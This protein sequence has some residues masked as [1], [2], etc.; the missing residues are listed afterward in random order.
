MGRESR[1]ASCR[2][3]GS[4]S[5]KSRQQCRGL[6]IQIPLPPSGIPAAPSIQQQQLV[7]WSWCDAA[8]WVHCSSQQR[9][10]SE[11]RVKRGGERRKRG[12]HEC[13]WIQPAEEGC[14]HALKGRC[15]DA[16]EGER[17][18]QDASYLGRACAKVKPCDR[19]LPLP[20]RGKRLRD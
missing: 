5:E 9:R 12:E 1:K 13:A 17:A 10:I 2:G 14:R 11:E 4:C 8:Q 16:F 15:G 3:R 18:E 19:R 20:S 7:E 6:R